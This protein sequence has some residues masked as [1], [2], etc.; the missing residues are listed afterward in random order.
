M[1]S[2]RR[3]PLSGNGQQNCMQYTQ[4]NER[5]IVHVGGSALHSTGNVRHVLPNVL[6][7]LQQPTLRDLDEDDVAGNVVVGLVPQDLGQNQSGLDAGR[8]VHAHLAR[9]ARLGLGFG[10]AV[11]RHPKKDLADAGV[12]RIPGLDHLA[13]RGKALL[14]PPLAGVNVGEQERGRLVAAPYP[15][16][17]G[18]A[19][20]RVPG[21]QS[22]GFRGLGVEGELAVLGGQLEVASL[23][24]QTG[25]PEP[26]GGEPGEFG[27]QSLV[28]VVCV[29]VE[30]PELVADRR[31]E[32]DRDLNHLVR[33][34]ARRPLLPLL[35][36]GQRPHR[37]VQHGLLAAALGA[38]LRRQRCRALHHT[39]SQ[40]IKVD[41]KVFSHKV[42][43]L[44]T[45]N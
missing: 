7:V 31:V 10:L 27:G 38:V 44:E 42:H 3:A 2:W 28:L 22:L 23:Q 4:V 12:V 6:G 41:P 26:R 13:Q 1:L 45:W 19:A 14:R 30:A 39:H 32:P 8:V 9:V 17:P 5:H 11:E 34:H 18:V 37:L 35:A 29:G 20:G 33:A 25:P 36:P 24:S 21:T 16:G 15:R 40:V 43:V